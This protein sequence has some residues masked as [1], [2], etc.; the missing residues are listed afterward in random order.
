MSMYIFVSVYMCVRDRVYFIILTIMVEISKAYALIN[1]HIYS[2][3][4]CMLR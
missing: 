1:K 4:S 2:G 3:F